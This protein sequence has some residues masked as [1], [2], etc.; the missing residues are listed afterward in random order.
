MN[1]YK[2]REDFPVLKDI[3]YL[4]SG[5]TSQTPIP[6]VEAMN[7]Y[8]Y[9]YAANYGRGAH[10][11]ARKTTDKYEDSRENVADFINAKSEQIVFTRNTTESINMVSHGLNWKAG[12]HIITTLIEHH[13][14]LLPWIRLKKKGVKVS[15]VAPD[16]TG[17]V[18]P[19]SIASCINSKT[20]LIAITHVSNVF[21]SILNI[22]KVTNI[23][24]KEGVYT[25]IDGAQSVGHIPINIKDI[26]C[27]FFAA[28]GH[29]GLLGPQGTGIL[30]IK[31][32]ENLE[33]VY[34]GGGT[35]HSV[36]TEDYKLDIIPNRFEAGTPNIPGVIGLGRAVEYVKNIGVQNIEKHVTNLARETAKSLSEIPNVEVYGPKERSAVVPFNIKGLNPHDVSM[37]L[38]ETRKICTRSG[39]HCAIPC[40][41]FLEVEGT[42]RASFALYNTKEE[43]EIFINTVEEIA[44]A[45]T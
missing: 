20:K 23:A 19:D 9:E 40:I 4:D 38:D 28:S 18:S 24:K 17:I 37:I 43:V 5:A 36:T 7:E 31:D 27:D 6:V 12:D 14:N 15:I 8:F 33:P 3:I 10:R 2:I 30:Y 35:V 1:V 13:S 44:K 39:H 16:K 29:K 45:L 21:G 11:L 22:K 25:L 34:L 41:N 32:P 42:V 26:D